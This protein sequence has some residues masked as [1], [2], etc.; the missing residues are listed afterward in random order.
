MKYLPFRQI[1]FSVLLPL[2]F[3]VW[4]VS[5]CETYFTRIYHDEL[6]EILLQSDASLLSGEVS[7]AEVVR[8]NI[9]RYVTE[10]PSFSLFSVSA[11]EVLTAEGEPVYPFTASSL[12]PFAFQR[13]VALENYRLIKDG[14]S[15]KVTLYTRPDSPLSVGSLCLFGALALGG[16]F[17]IYRRQVAY[18]CEER[19]KR[20][21]IIVSLTAEGKRVEEA[22][23][24]LSDRQ[25]T[26]TRN[27]EKA[28]RSLSVSH[29][30]Q[31]GMVEEIEV[32]EA[33]LDENEADRIRQREEMAILSESITLH[34][35]DHGS[36]PGKRKAR[37]KEV[38]AKRL[39]TLYKGLR[40]DD[41][42]MTGFLALEEGM[43]LKC[44]ALIHQLNDD[45]SAVIVKRKIFGGKGMDTFFETEFAYKGRLYFMYHPG[46]QVGILAIGTKNSQAA[47][48][49]FLN[50][51][52]GGVKSA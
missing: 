14:L 27:L 51:I 1:V 52:S 19:R 35:P 16:L 39:K 4:S 13:N 34:A 31:S 50:R 11:I 38:T 42:A 6:E 2:L 47:E 43:R 23:E 37:E 46:G 7:V 20:D 17:I 48:M 5:F 22:F 15:L 44:E 30:S 26:L 12:P 45:P 28:R 10:H 33:L 9:S 49:G 18:V 8:K 36:R 32:L 25:D 29:E 21:L 41:R 3:Y 24:A 40:I